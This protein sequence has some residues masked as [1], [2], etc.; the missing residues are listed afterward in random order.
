MKNLSHFVACY[1]INY[2]S[3]PSGNWLRMNVTCP[4][5]TVKDLIL[6]MGSKILILL[7]LFLLTFK[8]Q[9]VKHLYANLWTPKRLTKYELKMQLINMYDKIPLNIKIKILRS[10]ND[11]SSPIQ[12]PIKL[13]TQ[14]KFKMLIDKSRNNMYSYRDFSF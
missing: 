6:N 7:L 14:I 11:S 8:E 12:L 4:F 3:H 13:Q 2:V 1:K 9:N 5:Y 10:I